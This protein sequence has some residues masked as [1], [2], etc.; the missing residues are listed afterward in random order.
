MTMSPESY[1]RFLDGYKQRRDDLNGFS[2]INKSGIVVGSCYE[3][4]SFHID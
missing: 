2:L 1:L 4:D 3:K